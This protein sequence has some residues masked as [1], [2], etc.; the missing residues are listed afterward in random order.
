MSEMGFQPDVRGGYFHP[1]RYGGTLRSCLA[2]DPRGGFQ[3]EG[4]AHAQCDQHAMY[5]RIAC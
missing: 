2:S 3:V 5:A 4:E 1:R